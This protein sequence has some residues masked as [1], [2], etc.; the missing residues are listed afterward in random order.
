M[1]AAQI[2]KFKENLP[3]K[4]YCTDAKEFGLLI[5][6]KAMAIKKK[7]IQ[8]NKPTSVKFLAFD[9]DYAGADQLI[10]DEH[11][12]P[13]NFIAFNKANGR[14]HVFYALEVEVYT[15]E[16]ARRKPIELLAAIERRLCTVL[17]ADPA[18][19]GFIVKNPCHSEWEVHEYKTTPWGLKDFL[20]Y[21]ELPAKTPKRTKDY[22]LGRNVYLFDDTR[23][24]AY[25]QVLSYRLSGA[26]DEFF[27]AVLNYAVQ[28]NSQFPVP[29]SFPEVKAT[30]KSI[31]KWTWTKYTGRMSDQEFSA[32]QAARGARSGKARVQKT[33][34]SRVMANLYSM[35]GLRQS[36]I[37]EILEL[38]KQ[39]VSRWLVE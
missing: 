13:P 6:S 32:K 20:E 3:V 10:G 22:G 11:L 33:L 4:P 28:K 8:H 30:A 1:I 17:Q 19:T 35:V 38:P 25:A 26:R 12:P 2:E 23:Y 18:Y 24:W 14:S 36:R 16:N 27:D 21:I 31:A 29:L 34:E 39:S 9:C 15:V 5:R 37:C 7:Y